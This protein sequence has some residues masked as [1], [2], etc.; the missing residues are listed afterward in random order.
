MAVVTR[1]VM[2]EPL[3]NLLWRDVEIWIDDCDFDSFADLC[4]TYVVQAN[5]TAP[6][7]LDPLCAGSFVREFRFKGNRAQGHRLFQ[8]VLYS[9]FGEIL[10]LGRRVASQF[11]EIS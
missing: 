6:Q 7:D 5:H 4:L 8:L 9:N 3:N 11:S 1:P 2:G 10:G